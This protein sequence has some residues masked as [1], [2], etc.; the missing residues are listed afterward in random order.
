MLGEHIKLKRRV[1]TDLS[2]SSHPSHRSWLVVGENEVAMGAA[3]VDLVHVTSCDI[4]V[5]NARETECVIQFVP[6]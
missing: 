1:G 2:G 5:W 4:V 6:A 3:Y